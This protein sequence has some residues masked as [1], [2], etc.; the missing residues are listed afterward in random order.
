MQTP[1]VKRSFKLSILEARLAIVANI[2][3]F[4]VKYW[5][6]VVVGSVALVAD[7]WHTLSDSA[8]SV[9]V[10]LGVKVSQKPADREHP[11]GH[12]RAELIATL[13]IGAM[14]AFV[15]Y[16]F[17]KESWLRLQGG[18]SVVFGTLAIIVTAVSAVA[19]EALAQFAFWANRK[20]PSNILRA[21]AWHHRSDAMSS[22]ALLIGMFFSRFFWWMDA[23]LGFL[24][25]ALIA[26]A[27]VEI[28]RDAVH[29]F[30]GTAVEPE[31]Q[32]KVRS[33]CAQYGIKPDS[34][35]HFHQH[36]YGGHTELTFHLR[37]PNSMTVETSHRIAR[38]VEAHIRKDMDMEAT[39]HVEPLNRDSE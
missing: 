13:V 9:V 23:A 33:I 8:S 1:P 3:L 16:S 14:L 21:D 24:V 30:L 28:F 36:E 26:Y 37:L 20:T 11:F 17:F 6:G 10:L 31:T 32:K 5:V 34:L 35:H 15:A 29:Q 38:D 4:A 22:L 18:E 27:A 25:A 39:I 2:V 12:G 19:K 7:A